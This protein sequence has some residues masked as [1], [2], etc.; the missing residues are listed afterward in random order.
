MIL[1]LGKTLGP[2]LIP[3]IIKIVV[4]VHVHVVVSVSVVFIVVDVVDVVVLLLLI[5]ITYL[6]SL[7]KIRS[8]PAEIL[9]TLSSWWVGGGLVGRGPELF[10]V[11]P[12][13][14]YLRLS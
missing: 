6:Y 1:R 11:K 7:V 8:I 5:P 2:Q 13:C 10:H 9:A 14:C 4:V 3:C 12:N